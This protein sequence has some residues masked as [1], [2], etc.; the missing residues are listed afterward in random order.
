MY[1]YLPLVRPRIATHLRDV[2]I[3]LANAQTFVWDVQS[4]AFLWPGTRPDLYGIWYRWCI[5]YMVC[6]V[7]HMDMVAI[8]ASETSN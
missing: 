6:G 1:L 7:W 5:W 2:V 4:A 3:A 8:A